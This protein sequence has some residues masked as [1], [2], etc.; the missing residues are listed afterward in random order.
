[1][2]CIPCFFLIFYLLI[3]IRTVVEVVSIVDKNLLSCLD[4]MS[5]CHAG[6]DTE[7]RVIKSAELGIGDERVIGLV[8]QGGVVG[9]LIPAINFMTFHN[10]PFQT[11]MSPGDDSVNYYV[12]RLLPQNSQESFPPK[13]TV[14]LSSISARNS[15]SV[16]AFSK[17]FYFF[18]SNMNCVSCL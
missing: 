18:I 2:Q 3:P 16:E 4:L 12:L 1:M 6:D 9:S 11:L 13:I 15:D 14:H 8:G 10:C 17:E 7:A 5:G